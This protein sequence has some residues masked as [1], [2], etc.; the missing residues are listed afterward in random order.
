MKLEDL[1]IYNL[2]ME[3][4]NE[5]WNAV[6]EWDAFARDTIGKQWVRAIDSVG[7]NISEGMGRDSFK[8]AR[9][10]YFIGRGS[11]YESK[12][13][14]DKA[15]QRKLITEEKYKNLY[16]NLNKLGFKMNNFLKT[17]NRLINNK[18]V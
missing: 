10:F 11:L 15:F 16:D 14:L 1:E 6:R 2:S 12:T 9:K 8:D 3:V 17:H 13:W 4:S 18:E 5:V 7:A